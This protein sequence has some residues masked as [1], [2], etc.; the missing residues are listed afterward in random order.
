MR[1]EFTPI[2]LIGATRLVAATEP[3]GGGGELHT[4]TSGAGAGGDEESTTMVYSFA[5]I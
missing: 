5:A 3:E 1:S 4:C 2:P